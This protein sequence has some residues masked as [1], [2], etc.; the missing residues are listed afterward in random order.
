[1]SH[2]NDIVTYSL[3]I[4]ILKT[5]L[6]GTGLPLKSGLP[7]NPVENN[8]HITSFFFSK[9]MKRKVVHHFGAGL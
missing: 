4:Y 2:E 6:S 1:M 9:T 5:M 3:D 8:S 7:T